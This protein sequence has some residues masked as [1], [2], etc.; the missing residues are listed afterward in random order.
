[1]LTTAPI[2]IGDETL[3]PGAPL[4]I[5]L[6]TPLADGAVPSETTIR[7]PGGQVLT[8]PAGIRIPAVENPTTVGEALTTILQRTSAVGD[9]T[10]APG[11]AIVVPPGTSV[12]G[13][14]EPSATVLLQPGTAVQVSGRT[15][16]VRESLAV[17]VSGAPVGRPSTLPA[18]GDAEPVWWPAGL[19]L[20]MVLLGWRLRHIS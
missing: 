13:A 8:L 14:V 6:D 1:V 11:T 16:T 10:Y 17:T 4:E 7:L 15:Q 3:A 20:L 5:P 9:T 18:T 19:G 12:L 2:A